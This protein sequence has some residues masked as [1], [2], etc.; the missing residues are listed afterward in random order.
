M[1][2]NKKIA[3]LLGATGLIGNELLKL[4]L[5][6]SYYD[7][8]IILVRKSV[9]IDNPKLIEHIIDF[10]TPNSWEH[11]VIG[12]ILFMAFGTTI[13][14]AGSKENQYKIDVTYQLNMAKA[15][16]KNGVQTI[17]LVS[18]TGANAKS[19]FFYNRI[20]GE[21]DNLIKE[22]PFNQTTIFKPSVLMG[23]RSE[24]RSGEKSAIKIM[25]VL[26]F[27]PFIKKYRP[28]KGKTV[29]KA[30]LIAAKLENP[31]TEYKL[32]EIQALTKKEPPVG[33]SLY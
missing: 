3:I 21:L 2:E 13:K 32:D 28:I 12:D 4:L 18:S 17:L 9:S 26:S 23:E 33:S 1:E 20:K 5:Q 31:Q 15:A 29:A 11:L 27:I 22:L 7:K 25:Q 30:M 16:A 8:V 10:D 6:D 24:K 14:K 19:S